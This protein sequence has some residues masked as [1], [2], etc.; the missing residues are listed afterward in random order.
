MT[1]YY[2]GHTS[3][4]QAGPPPLLLRLLGPLVVVSTLGLL[5]TG[6]LLVLLGE[7]RSRQS[8]LTVLGSG[9]DWVAAHQ[10]FF[11]VW[12]ESSGCTCSGGSSR[13][14]G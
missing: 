3:Y 12:V 4:R 7:Q 9:C 10:G 8:L 14:C 13:P 2:L 11:A 6:V 5:G 1:R